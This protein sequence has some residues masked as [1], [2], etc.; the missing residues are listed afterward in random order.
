MDGTKTALVPGRGR[1][2]IRARPSGVNH[3]SSSD[4]VCNSCGV[5]LMS[6]VSCAI[7]RTLSLGSSKKT[8]ASHI[9]G[10][11]ETEIT[12]GDDDSET[13]VGEEVARARDH[14]RIS[15][16]APSPHRD[17]RSYRPDSGRTTTIATTAAVATAVVRTDA[18]A[19][20]SDASHAAG[21]A[22]A[23]ALSA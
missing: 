18:N 19:Y 6:S 13:C 2:E 16:A 3:L 9:R 5:R 8:R 23:V 20:E 10:P 12:H 17:E 21:A 14:S 1:V 15:L 4:S 7:L 11:R 22:A